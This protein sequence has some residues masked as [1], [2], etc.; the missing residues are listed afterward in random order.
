M[1]KTLLG[2]DKENAKPKTVQYI[3]CLNCDEEKN[4]AHF[5][6][7]A[8]R[9]FK[10]FPLCKECIIENVDYKDGNTVLTMLRELDI[11]YIKNIW[12]RTRIIEPENTIIAYIKLMNT[13]QY[14]GM[15]WG[16]SQ[17]DNDYGNDDDVIY[18]EDWVGSFSKRDVD[19][20]NKYMDKLQTD[21]NIQTINH[22]D[23]A[24]KIA[25][26]SLAMDRAFME[27]MNGGSE[28]KYKALKDVFDTLSRAAQFSE[29]RR[30]SNDITL[31]SFGAVFNRVEKGHW[32]PKHIPT[33][34]DMYDKLLDQFSNIEKSL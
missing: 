33:Q 10:R 32:V 20:L 28:T 16:A 25:K 6:G 15:S 8:K 29:E 17:F 22:I 26:A 24:R 11:A 23:Y 5:M 14:A 2:I 1:S 18:S 13:K 12:E 4:E 3:T 27:L 34:K 7:A 19:H 30:S 21:Y 31:G 9:Q